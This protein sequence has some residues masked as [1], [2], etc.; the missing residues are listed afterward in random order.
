VVGGRLADELKQDAVGLAGL[1]AAFEHHA[2]AGFQREGGDLDERVWTGLEDRADDADWDGELVEFEILVEFAGDE[3][4]PEGVVLAGD[5]TNHLD[6]AVEFG[7]REFEAID[8]RLG[9]LAGFKQFLGSFDIF[10]IGFLNRRAVVVDGVSDGVQCSLSV[11]VIDVGEIESGG[12]GGVN[13]RVDG[14]VSRSG[15]IAGRVGITHCRHR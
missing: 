5:A 9:V 11:G 2:V 4:L 13:F 6:D 7:I 10:S 15:G 1:A 14:L 3:R 8:E 12:L